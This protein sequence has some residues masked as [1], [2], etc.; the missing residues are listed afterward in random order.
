VGL[1]FNSLD[2]NVTNGK[3]A[4][5][6]MANYLINWYIFIDGLFSFLVVIV[7][8]GAFNEPDETLIVAR[9]DSEFRNLLKKIKINFTK[10]Y[11]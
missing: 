9:K 3:L 6:K 1:E 10:L 8:V 5:L 4:L 7:I 11:I 2:A